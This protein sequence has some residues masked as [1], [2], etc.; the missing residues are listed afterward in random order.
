MTEERKSLKVS[1]ETTYKVEGSILPPV[2]VMLCEI[3]V[4][5]IKFVTTEKLQ[6]NVVL[7]LMIKVS[8]GSDPIPAQGRVVW[9]GH[10]ASKFLLDT[11]IEFTRIES[12]EE[13]R[14]ASFITN[15]VENIKVLRLNIRCPMTVETGYSLFVTPDVEKKC[16]SGDIGVEGMKLF[17]EEKVELGSDMKI[18][19]NLPRGWGAVTVSATVV[20]K[21]KQMDRMIPV[22]V[23]FL[24]IQNQA[25]KRIL[26]YIDYTLSQHPS[27]N[28]GSQ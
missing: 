23:K 5:G 18:R 17:L 8:D 12:K 16:E 26:H 28:I 3:G 6:T 14:I 13:S 1:G 4:K 24:D 25:K 27:D 7:D 21:G 20:W 15:S 9:Q 2:S 10:G 11:D 19:F 22:G